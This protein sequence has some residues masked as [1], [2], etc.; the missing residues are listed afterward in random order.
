MYNCASRRQSWDAKGQSPAASHDCLREAQLYTLRLSLVIGDR[1][2]TC[3]IS[4]TRQNKIYDPMCYI[5]LETSYLIIERAD[6]FWPFAISFGSPIRGVTI[7]YISYIS[8]IGEKI[9]Y[10]LY[11]RPKHTKPPIFFNILSSV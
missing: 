10:I 9:S 5:F 8:Y 2:K 1:S 6:H 4:Y 7:S 11:R 3:R